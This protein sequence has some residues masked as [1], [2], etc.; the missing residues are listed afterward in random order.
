M[1]WG[2]FIPTFPSEIFYVVLLL[3]LVVLMV[4]T[5]AFPPFPWLFQH[6]RISYA[7]VAS[8][9]VSIIIFG[10]FNAWFI[11]TGGYLGISIARAGYYGMH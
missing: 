6:Q 8:A 10:F 5:I 7:L 2:E 1:P 4:S 9:G 3:V 11:F